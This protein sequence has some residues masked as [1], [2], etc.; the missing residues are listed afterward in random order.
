MAL[1][2]T[3]KVALVILTLAMIPM[4]FLNTWLGLATAFAAYSIAAKLAD[5]ALDKAANLRGIK[6]GLLRA[7]GRRNGNQANP[8]RRRRAASL[9]DSAVS[10]SDV[11]CL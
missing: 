4:L 11:Q 3:Y 9:N 10:L 1:H 5:G 8:Q 2:R 6:R 7:E